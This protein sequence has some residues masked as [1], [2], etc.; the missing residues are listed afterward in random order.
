MPKTDPKPKT[1][2]TA[3]PLMMQHMT[4]DNGERKAKTHAT[5]LQQKKNDIFKFEGE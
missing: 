1:P 4:N 2:G 3:P 5:K